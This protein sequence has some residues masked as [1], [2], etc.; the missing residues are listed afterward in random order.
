[1]TQPR[2][3]EEARIAAK[4]AEAA[5]IRAKANFLANMSHEIRTP[6]N[7]VIGMTELLLDTPLQSAQREFAETIRTSATSLLGIINDILDFSKIEAGKLEV[8]RAP[9]HVRDCVE[10]VGMAMAVHAAAKDLELIV[11]VDPGVPDRVLGDATRLRQMLTNLISNAIKFTHKGEV[12]VEVFPLALAERA[13][14]AELRGARHRHRHAGGNRL[15]AVRALRAGGRFEHAQLRRHGPRARHRA[16][17]RHADGRASIDVSRGPAAARRSR[18]RC[19]SMPSTTPPMPVSTSR[20]IT[21]GKRVLVMDDN[22][23]NRR[24]LCGQ[25]QPVGF[26]V[27]AA[28]TGAETLEDAAR[29]AARPARRSTS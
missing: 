19:P 17:A 20:V 18:S 8:E 28:G 6:M 16:P 9:M 21:R 24:V 1:M 7:G 11:N 2:E 10:D 5:A 4:D 3:A 22:P 25:L 26:D 15:A 29:R 23:T 12:V 27:V 14:A 13:R